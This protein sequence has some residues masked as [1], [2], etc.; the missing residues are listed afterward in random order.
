MRGGLIGDHIGHNAA[1]QQF[2]QNFRCIANQRNGCGDAGMDRVFRPG[3]LAETAVA[4]TQVGQD[5]PQVGALGAQPG[6]QVGDGLFLQAQA[7]MDP[8]LVEEE[9]AE[10]GFEAGRGG[11]ALPEGGPP[12]TPEL[13]T[14]D[15]GPPFGEAAG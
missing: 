12:L 14:G 3:E 11:M 10:P 2:G 5:G 8:A 1:R 15:A 4:V 9:G 7:G 13:S 6:G